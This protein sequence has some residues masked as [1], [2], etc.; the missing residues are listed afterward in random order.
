MKE[1]EIVNGVYGFRPDGT[2]RSKPAGYGDVVTVPDG[3]AVRLVKLGVG[4]IIS[5]ALPTYPDTR[6]ADVATSADSISAAGVE[7]NKPNEENETDGVEISDTLDIV[8]GHLTIDSLMRMTRADMEHLAEDL[9]VDVSKCKNK[10]EI[11]TLI[12]AVDIEPQDTEGTLPALGA[13]APIE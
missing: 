5:E 3:E 6:I 8:D 12:A 4:R 7:D 2:K 1:V 13:E 9:D 10:S 11:A